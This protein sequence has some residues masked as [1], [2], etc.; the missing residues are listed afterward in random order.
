VLV[1]TNMKHSK[2]PCKTDTYIPVCR[3]CDKSEYCTSQ[4]SSITV[5]KGGQTGSFQYKE[6]VQISGSHSSDYEDDSLLG[7]GVV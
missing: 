2:S 4:E 1:V 5:H 6:H 7:Y 3:M